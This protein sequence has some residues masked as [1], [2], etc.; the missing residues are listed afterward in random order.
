MVVNL[1]MTTKRSQRSSAGAAEQIIHT[2]LAAFG[3]GAGRVPI[4]PPA[5]QSFREQFTP[6]IDAA[7]ERPDW[8]DA[9]HREKAYVQAYAEAMGERA[10]RLAAEDRRT[11]ITA[12]DVDGARA[13]LRGYLPVAGRWCPV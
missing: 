3:R 10:R 13:K 9:W 6:H 4:G 1:I 12:D 2:A 5:V 11:Y 8:Q 7:L